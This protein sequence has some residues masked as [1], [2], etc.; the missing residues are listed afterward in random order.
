MTKHDVI[1][2]LDGV[3]I[4]VGTSR[5]LPQGP[6]LAYKSVTALFFMS[7][8]IYWR[9]GLGATIVLAKMTHQT[10][11]ITMVYFFAS[12]L[13]ALLCRR[14]IRN[15]AAVPL[16][17]WADGRG[18]T[19]PHNNAAAK[20]TS[21][22]P[23]EVKSANSVS[24]KGEAETSSAEHITK[25]SGSPVPV[26]LRRLQLVVWNIAC[27]LSLIVVALFWFADYDGGAVNSIDILAHGVIAVVM[28][29]DQFLIADE[30][31]MRHV[32]I[33]QL[34]GVFYVLFN[35]TWYYEGWQE[36]MLYKVLD[37]DNKPLT[38]CIYGAV[39][40]LVLVP[41]FGFL[42]LIIHRYYT[43]SAAMAQVS[44]MFYL[45]QRRMCSAKS[46]MCIR[47]LFTSRLSRRHRSLVVG[48]PSR[49]LSLR[50]HLMVTHRD[51]RENH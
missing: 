30:F 28:A 10:W 33:S 40:I 48:I 47:H 9:E 20:A 49:L 3:E 39:C 38:A 1:V 41:L 17:T 45:F 21:A 7:W 13:S 11:Y 44:G 46:F 27:I 19:P 34:Y 5:F 16:A 31:K 51:A 35:I 23:V 24:G 37:W 43:C 50:Q 8:A 22:N 15:G 25:V 14:A 32:I 2:T 4:R 12:A 26:S 42:H 6:F 18:S 36:K 29:M